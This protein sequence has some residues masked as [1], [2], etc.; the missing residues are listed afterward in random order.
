MRRNK[1]L[2]VIITSLILATGTLFAISGC[3]K[4]SVTAKTEHEKVMYHCPMHPTYISDKQGDCPI[5]GMKLVKMEAKTEGQ[6]VASG[7]GASS[8][9]PAE[10]KSL[11]EVCIEHKC[12][13]NNCPMNV[14]TNMKPGERILCPV[15]GEVVST[16]NGKVVEIIQAS[17]LPRTLRPRSQP[18]RK[19]N[20]RSSIIETQ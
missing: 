1:Y 8:P 18:P 12:T 20:A 15:C 9:K 3:G 11:E 16:A 4:S 2:F 17:A 10:E 13:M 7:Q 6:P 19:K 14:K 5:C